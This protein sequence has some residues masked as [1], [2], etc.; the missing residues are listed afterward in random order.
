MPVKDHKVT[1][2]SR[3]ARKRSRAT[4]AEKRN[5]TISQP[6][7]GPLVNVAPVFSADHKY[8]T[9]LTAIESRLY[10]FPSQKCVARMPIAEAYFAVDL[11]LDSTAQPTKDG[12]PVLWLAMRNGALLRIDWSTQASPLKLDLSEFGISRIHRIIDVLDQSKKFLLATANPFIDS[13]ILINEIQLTENIPL[14]KELGKFKDVCLFA[15][16]HSRSHIVVY[17]PKSKTSGFELNVCKIDGSSFELA[18]IKTTKR[19][20][21]V[22]VSD[23]GVVALG[24]LNG[25]IELH[26]PCLSDSL[27]YKSN[28]AR[29]GFNVRTL[30]W[31]LSLVRALAFSLDGE[32]L[33]SGGNEKVLLFWQLDTGAVQFLPRLPGPITNIVVDRTSTNY[34]LCVGDNNDDIILFSATDLDARLQVAGV[35]ACHSSVPPLALSQATLDPV[36]I[37]T[38]SSLKLL[39]LVKHVVESEDYALKLSNEAP[40]DVPNYSIYPTTVQLYSPPGQLAR[41]KL[42]F[43]FPTEKNAQIQIYD[44]F[45]CEQVAM[46][47]VARTLQTGKVLFE[48]AI[49]DPH[50][51][52]LQISAG[53]DWMATVDELYTPPIDGL[54]S[55]EDM[56]V[57]LKFWLC[58][59]AVSSSEQD[60]S[61]VSW[62]LITKIVNPHGPNVAVKVMSAAPLSYH[63]GMA[64]ATACSGGGLRLWRPRF[65]RLRNRQIEWSAR[66]VIAPSY[67]KAISRSSSTFSIADDGSDGEVLLAWSPDGS[68]ILLTQ[69]SSIHVVSVPVSGSTDFSIVKTIS[70]YFESS[71]RSI[72]M[73][74]PSVVVLTSCRL[75]VYNVIGSAIEWSTAV[76][77][78]TSGSSSLMVTGAGNSYI[79]LAINHV[80]FPPVSTLPIIAANVYV[81]TKNSPVPLYAA[82]HTRPI[83][84]IHAIPPTSLGADGFIFVDTDNMIYTLTAPSTADSQPIQK[85]VLSTTRASEL[86]LSDSSLVAEGVTAILSATNAAK[87]TTARAPSAAESTEDSRDQVILSSDIVDRVFTGPEYATGDLSLVFDKLLA[88]VGQKE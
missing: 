80:A 69:G 1:S 28:E 39:N 61:G 57:T 43:Y 75:S 60:Q 42:Y 8:L 36:E 65:P 10:A 23:N 58:R 11:V 2:A 13:N 34:A 14:V 59:L 74:G 20:S 5:W 46:H 22:A 31:H 55:E 63:K 26:Y 16:S 81:F 32:Y 9:V 73:L 48:E 37:L 62:N 72:S 82:V 76:G 49:E 40:W 77:Y 66:H 83:S 84:T 25:S 4:R 53:N 87:Y 24:F 18:S 45:N 15:I 35:K 41:P 21:T 56:T 67:S 78:T 12:Y 47:A 29:K 17:S 79:A 7:G 44:A 71:I 27:S 88:V 85:A 86:D 68:I 33:L 64:F 6:L 3:G 51:T 54:L 70:G 50:I 38:S 52:Q 19:A 30:K